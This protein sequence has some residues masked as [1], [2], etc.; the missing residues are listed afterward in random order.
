[1]FPLVSITQSI[2]S[3]PSTSQVGASQPLQIHWLP[4]IHEPELQR[5]QCQALFSSCSSEF[6]HQKIYL[7][8]VAFVTA[9]GRWLR[10]QFPAQPFSLSSGDRTTRYIDTLRALR[11]QTDGTSCPTC[12]SVEYHHCFL[13]FFFLFFFGL[14]RAAPAAYRHS[15]ARGLIRAT[16]ASLY[17]SH[18]N[19]G[20][21]PCLPPTPQLMATPD[22]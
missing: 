2:T 13:A 15:Q 7:T 22:P 18:S 4:S 1:M 9:K 20:S 11:L 6:S 12:P 10:L 8:F 21:K 14:F 3:V 5:A 19:A 16:A 17:H